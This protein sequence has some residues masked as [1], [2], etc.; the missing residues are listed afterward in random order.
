MISGVPIEAFAFFQIGQKLAINIIGFYLFYFQHG[1]VSKQFAQSTKIASDAAKAKEEIKSQLDEL[2]HAQRISEESKQFSVD[3][4]ER[5]RIELADR[6]QMLENENSVLSA[7]YEDLKAMTTEEKAEFQAV[8]DELQRKVTVNKFAKYNMP[9][10]SI[11]IELHFQDLQKSENNLQAQKS[12][13]EKEI[14][15]AAAAKSQIEEKY[16][17]TTVELQSFQAKLLEHSKESVALQQSASKSKETNDELLQRLEQMS[18]ANE[19]LKNQHEEMKLNNETILQK[20]HELS[21][22][23]E[24]VESIFLQLIQFFV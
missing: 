14:T 5:E 22:T 12:A 4:S 17:G 3:N 9:F 1:E 19:M 23:V 15:T 6:C 8:T 20:G 13:L 10:E 7:R 21:R 24:E 16:H 11:N 18:E 2:Q